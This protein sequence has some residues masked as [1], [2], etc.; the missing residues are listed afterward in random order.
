MKY[1]R[2]IIPIFVPHIGCTHNC[3]FCNQ[4]SITGSE[5][6]KDI[7]NEEFVRKT[8]EEYLTTIEKENTTIEVSFFGGTF[9]AIDINKQRELLQVALE[10]K[11]NNKIDF[12]RLSTR[13]DNIDIKI[14]EHLKSYKVDIIELGVQSLDDEVLKLS[15]RGH[16]ADDVSN[17]SKL[18]KEYGFVL[19]HQIM[20]GLPG[21][22]MEKDIET[23]KKVIEMKP[24]IC[25]IYPALIIK[26]TPMEKMFREGEYT[27]YTLEK[28]VEVGKIIYSM[29]VNNNINV[30]R[31]GLQATEEISEGKDII[32]GPF[33][34][35]FRELIE[36]SIFNTV[37]LR[38]IDNNFT[39]E[40]NLR[41]NPKDISKLFAYKKKFFNELLAKLSTRKINI[42]QDEN[43]IKGDVVLS[44]ENYNES[45]SIDESYW[46]KEIKGYF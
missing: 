42:I 17:A 9:T 30:I 34:P 3:V 6:N 22:T 25:R 2:R 8:I 38:N 24:D 33:H 44:Y 1:K 5:G 43:I 13:P 11:E 28:A 26:D 23:T 37:L 15:A 31:V 36:G 32:A 4:N 27:P 14:L 40:V 39:G 41:I 20:I 29:L 21:D 12:I 35:A 19:G 46:H 18:I 7:I 16:S 10:Y 45:M